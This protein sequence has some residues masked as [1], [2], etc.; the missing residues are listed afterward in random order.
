MK[1]ALH[2][3]L[4]A[5]A[6]NATCITASGKHPDPAKSLKDMR[7]PPSLFSAIPRAFVHI[8]GH[9]LDWKVDG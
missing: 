4:D 5:L 1:T 6:E 8:T 3:S 7:V 2:G 9:V